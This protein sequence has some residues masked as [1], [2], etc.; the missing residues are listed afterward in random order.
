MFDCIIIGG[1]L[2]GM[3]TARELQQAGA[4]VLILERGKL[5]GESSWAGGGI[6]SPLYPWR[7]ADAVNQLAHYG[8]EVYPQLAESLLDESGVDPQ[9]TQSGMMVLDQ[10]EKQ[11]ADKWARRWCTNMQHLGSRKEI[12][13]IE[14]AINADVEQAIWMPEIAQMRNPRLIK[15]LKGSLQSRG[16]EYMEHAEVQAVDIVDD[17]VRGVN[18]SAQSYT[19]DKVIIAG[20]AWSHDI[21][22]RYTKPPA[23]EPVKGQ[24][25][26]FGARPGLLK[27]MV[28]SNG[29]YLIPRRDGRILAGS[30]LEYTGFNKSINDT[31]RA[32][33]RQSA[34][35][36][37]PQLA[38]V[39]IEHH[40]AGLRPGTSDGI[41][42]ICSHP[43]IDGLY[44]NSGHFRNG[45][46]LG[47]A[48]ARLMK[49]IILQELPI[50]PTQ[51]YAL[52][53]LRL[54]MVRIRRR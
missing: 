19:A 51:A 15:A 9:Y 30:T 52:G 10:Q 16:I 45:V 14:P 6:L 49:N 38:N 41:P 31:A 47:A 18:T 53:M 4:E 32:D 25:I 2:I 7:Y 37:V 3:L 24:M 20:G 17:S 43:E 23:I 12:Q 44:I 26:L 35:E 40:W 39:E 22:Q 48:S 29:R 50:L 34:I 36:L 13:K 5:G 33:L 27:A 11:L 54:S 21:L 42:Y 1:G 28:L 8:Q 46:I